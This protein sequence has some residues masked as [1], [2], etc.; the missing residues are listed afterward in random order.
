LANPEHVALVKAGVNEIARWREMNHVIPN[1]PARHTL[2]YRLE[3]RTTS[4]VFAPEFVYGRPK[5]DLTGAILTRAKLARADLAFD[6]LNGVDLTNSNLRLADLQG[7]S[8]QSAHLSRSNLT[9]AVLTRANLSRCVLTRSNL[10][11]S[12]LGWAELVGADLSYSD[13]SSANLEGANLAN[14]DLTGANL[15][16]ASLNGANLRGSI[17]SSTCLKQADLT[18]ADLRGATFNRADFESASFYEAILGISAFINCDLSIAIALEFAR[19]TGPS[20]IALDTIAK[21]G[22]R[23]PRKFLVDAGVAA[24]LLDVQ[25]HLNGINRAF[26]SVL[27]IGSKGDEE[28]SA[29]LRNSLQAQQIHCWSIEAD[30]EAGL[31]SGEIILDHTDRFD[32]LVLLCTAASLESPQTRRYMSE[33]AGSR[34]PLSHRSVTTLAADTLFDQRGDELCALLK[35]G[36]VVDFVGWEDTA[37][38]ETA[39][40]S[41]A[42]ILSGTDS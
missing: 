42:R 37:I 39:V 7:A 24:P 28:L 1:T 10:S 13:L 17:L 12:T 9:R 23:I 4:E 35:Q 30:D 16:S 19:H 33:L 40:A 5:L 36:L 2:N 26:P 21:S 41:L 6:E 8:L 29:R 31:Q 3:D 27:M 14:A 15:T 11:W 34:S 20:T 32:R 18:G 38:F 22:G 25:D